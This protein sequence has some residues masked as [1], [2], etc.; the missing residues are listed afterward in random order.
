M[1]TTAKTGAL[2]GLIA[3]G[4]LLGW[5]PAAVADNFG[6]FWTCATRPPNRARAVRAHRLRAVHRDSACRRPARCSRPT[7]GT[8]SPSP[9]ARSRIRGATSR[10]R[11][12]SAPASSSGCICW[13]TSP[14]SS[15]LPFEQVQHAPADRVATATLEAVFPGAGAPIMAIAIMISTFGCNNGLILAGARAYY[16]MAR[17]GL[18][19]RSAGRLN[20]AKVPA[21]G[22]LLQGVL[23][24]R[25]GAAAHLRPGDRHLR[26]S[27]QQSARLRDFGGAD[28]LH[29]DH[30]RRVPAAGDAARR[31]AAVSGVRLSARARRCTSSAPAIILLVLFVY[32]TATT[33]PGLIIVLLGVPVY[34]AW[35]RRDLVVRDASGRPSPRWRRARTWTPRTRHRHLDAMQPARLRARP[36][37]DQIV[38]RAVAPHLGDRRA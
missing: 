1:F 11:W 38:H 10:C 20:A 29:P 34:F 16:A 19:F 36:V 4:L 13:P 7:P 28:L 33:W 31:A 35:R 25:A 3:L 6:N 37:A 17:D 9:P 26:Q 32:R 27:L 18:F 23:G 8:T 30:R 15:T 22:L 2:L 24:G 5:N 12:R 14:T 21:W